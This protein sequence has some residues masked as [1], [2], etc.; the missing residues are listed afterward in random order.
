ME[1]GGATTSFVITLWLEPTQDSARPEWRWR[2]TDG[3]SGEQRYFRWL[4]DLLGFVSER[5]AVPPPC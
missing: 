4:T 3:Q 2:V 1:P 5:S